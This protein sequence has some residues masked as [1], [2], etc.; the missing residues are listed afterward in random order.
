MNDLI[1]FGQRRVCPIPLNATHMAVKGDR[2]HIIGVAPTEEFGQPILSAK[3]DD[4]LKCTSAQ[5]TTLVAF[6]N[7]QV[8][9]AQ[10]KVLIAAVVIW[11]KGK[12]SYVDFPV[13]KQIVM[14]ILIHQF[15][16]ICRSISSKIIMVQLIVRINAAISLRPNLLTHPRQGKGIGWNCLYSLNHGAVPERKRQ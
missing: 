7:I 5:P 11:P 8:V 9:K 6:K 16:I 14:I 15:C 4:R 12:I 13:P 3:T 10:G 1:F 2:R